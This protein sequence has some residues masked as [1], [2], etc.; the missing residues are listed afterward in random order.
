[1]NYSFRQIRASG[2]GGL[3]AWFP[4][5]RRSSTEGDLSRISCR[6]TPAPCRR[7][8]LGSRDERGRA[9]RGMRAQQDR[10]SRLL[11][12]VEVRVQ[13]AQDARVLADVRA[14]VGAAVGLRVEPRSVQ[15]V[16][17]DELVVGV[18]GQDLGVDVSSL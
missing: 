14:R 18:E 17:L 8:A 7:A 4:G 10:R 16:V 11:A 12:E 9:G 15:E 5:M 13:V 2:S 3:L 1:M 6:I